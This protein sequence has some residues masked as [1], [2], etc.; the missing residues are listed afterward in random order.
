MLQRRLLGFCAEIERLR[1]RQRL[2]ARLLA[3]AEFRNG[4]VHGDRKAWVDL[5]RR[6]GFDEPEMTR[7]HVEFELDDPEGHDGFLR[8]IGLSMEE[9]DALR[10]ASRRASDS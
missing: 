6:A 3:L 8:G 4:A 2:L 10:R 7:W 5:L 9:R 1:E